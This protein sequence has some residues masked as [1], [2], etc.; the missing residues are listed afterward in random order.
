MLLQYCSPCYTYIF[1]HLP[2]NILTFQPLYS[3]HVPTRISAT[4]MQ[5]AIF[6]MAARRH[7]VENAHVLTTVGSAGTVVLI[8]LLGT[9]DWR[10]NMKRAKTPKSILT[11]SPTMDYRK[12]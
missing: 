12:T 5:V 8:R 4:K 9:K 11:A 2:R 3:R 1:V 10:M 6:K 7:V